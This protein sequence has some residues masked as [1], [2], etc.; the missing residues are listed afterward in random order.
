M[1]INLYLVRHGENYANLTK[2]FSYK[3]VDYSLT[4]KGQ[5]QARQT[6]EYFKH[7]QIQEIYSSPLKRAVETARIIAEP[8]GLHV[9]TMEQFREIN[10]GDLEGQPVSAE[11]WALNDRIYHDWFDGRPDSS[12]PGGEDYYTLARRMKEGISR[13]IAGKTERTIMIVS[14]GGI[15]TATLRELV[16]GVDMQRIHQKPS[17]NCSITHIA[18]RPAAGAFDGQLVEFAACAHIHG[19]AAQFVPGVPR[20]GELT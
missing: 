20:P 19:P 9:V 8:L 15:I 7:K 1:T 4:A 5:L 13:I 10:V 17:E 3:K 18:L 6:A 11:L 14:H 2:E 16:P 12:F